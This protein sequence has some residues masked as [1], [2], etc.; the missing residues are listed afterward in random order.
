MTTTEF[1]LGN[2]ITANNRVISIGIIEEDF[3]SWKLSDRVWNPTI[4]ISNEN[5][6]PIPLTEAILD[7]LGFV[8]NDLNGDDGYWQKL[9][10]EILQG[11]DGFSYNYAIDIS[12]FHQL[13]NLYYLITG[14]EIS[15]EPG[16]QI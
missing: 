13:Q 16:T 4:H 11:E 9:P 8:Y 7:D 3:I 12:Y 2:N 14:E 6:K 1:R 15:M 10:F 5:L